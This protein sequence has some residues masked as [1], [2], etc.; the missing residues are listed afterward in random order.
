MNI[1]GRCRRQHGG[2][3]N[4]ARAL[5]PVI[6]S[7]NLAS[8]WIYITGPLAGGVAADFLYDKV[9]APAVDPAGWPET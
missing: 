2:A 1:D 8:V 3:P 7:A 5:G 9:L 6:V 4:P